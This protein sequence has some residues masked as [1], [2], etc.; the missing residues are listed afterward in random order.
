MIESLKTGLWLTP[1]RLRIYPILLFVMLGCGL[2]FLIATA[3]DGHDWFER[4]LGPDFS[5]IWAAGQEVRAGHPERAYDIQVHREKQAELFGPSPD[6][7]LWSYPPYFLGVAALLA[8]FPYLVALLIW[9]ATTLS[10]Y[11]AAVLAILKSAGMAWT[12]A[13]IPVLAFPAVFVNLAH[14]QNGF[15]TA[16]LLTGGL[17]N[18]QARPVLAGALFACLA[19]KP[20]FAMMVPIA[21]L[22][23]GYW[24][25]IASGVLTLSVLT[26]GTL[27]LFGPDAWVSF[28]NG[29]KIA[30]SL[31]LE[32]GGA[33]FEK[34]QSL[35]AMT[36][37]FGGSIH[38]AY[39][40]QGTA[41]ILLIAGLAWLWHSASDFRLKGAAL[42][43]AALLA[44]PYSFDYDMVLL[45]PALAL[46]VS[47]GCEEGFHP[48][49]KT[50][51]ACVWISPLLARPLAT[52]VNV[53][54]GAFLMLLFFLAILHRAWCG[55]AL[56]PQT[57][58]AVRESRPC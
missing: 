29:I 5:E 47:Y 13:L 11:L 50:L 33:G 14:G 2:A 56:V 10:L 23:G 44:T 20:Q 12:K 21:L 4:P 38:Q 30:K 48:Y 41:L 34:M 25:C 31:V 17:L 58:L 46:A 49:E 32:H 36:R 6:F 16:A 7:Y 42:L 39:L 52:A 54:I 28:P 19:Y 51:F 37:L 57:A 3:H 9:Q 18:L 15:L 53:P 22:A 55:T 27:A 26:L 1:E 43:S 35:F 45:G 40:V 24:R 8:A